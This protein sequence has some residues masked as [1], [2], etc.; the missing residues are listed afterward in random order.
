MSS[1]LCLGHKVK[2][3][4]TV[5]SFPPKFRAHDRCGAMFRFVLLSRAAFEMTH[6]KRSEFIMNK[7][8]VSNHPFV[9]GLAS[10]TIDP[11][12]S[13][14]HRQSH[15][16]PNT[17]Q[18]TDTQRKD[19]AQTVKTNRREGTKNQSTGFGTCGK[20]VLLKFSQFKHV[21]DCTQHRR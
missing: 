15:N 5:R 3:V 13:N 9:T 12:L 11:F 8:V 21:T 6:L 14:R 4:L 18:N 16:K 17:T 20:V 19:G 2:L 7:D 1:R 10:S